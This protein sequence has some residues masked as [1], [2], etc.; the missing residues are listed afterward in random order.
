MGLCWLLTSLPTIIDRESHLGLFLL[1]KAM[2][3]LKEVQAVE[4]FITQ[5][6]KI[7]LKQD[8]FIFGKPVEIYLT[9]EQFEHLQLMVK[10]FKA[11]ITALWNE[12]VEKND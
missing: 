9:L 10:D 8:S 6:G 5:E 7:A 1:G 3:K 2:L 11:S 12:G 4:F